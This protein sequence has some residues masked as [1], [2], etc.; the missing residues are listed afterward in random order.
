MDIVSW[1][2]ELDFKD[3]PTWMKEYLEMDFQLS[4]MC[5]MFTLQ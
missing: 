3:N 5:C 2:L 4:N 1:S